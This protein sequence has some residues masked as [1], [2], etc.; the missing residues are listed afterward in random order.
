MLANPTA[1]E[2]SLLSQFAYQSNRVYLHTDTA[3]MPR[4]KRVW[5]SWNYLAHEEAGK[6]QAV[7]VTYWMKPFT[8]PVG[9]RHLYSSV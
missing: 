9:P 3:L 7:S 6:T 8:E 4:R 1:R 5:S 2:K